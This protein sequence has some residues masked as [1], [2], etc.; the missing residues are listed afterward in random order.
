[1]RE[2]QPT[3]VGL[4]EAATG[5]PTVIL[6]ATTAESVHSASGAIQ[7]PSFFIVGPPRTG[8]SWLHQ[9]LT[10]HALLPTPVKETRFFDKHYSRGLKWYLAQFPAAAANAKYPKGEVAPTYFASDAARERLAEIAPQAKI[11]CVFRNPVER[12]VSLYR[13]KRAYGLIPWSFE[14]AVERDPE[15]RETS[16]YAYNLKLWR[17][18]F[19]GENVMAAI[20]DDLRDDPQAFANAISDFI[21]APRFIL[22]ATDHTS[23]HT[24]E[25][26]THPRSYYR[27][28][29]AT[30]AADWFKAHRLAHVVTKFRRS[31]LLKLVLGGGKPFYPVSASR[32]NSLYIRFRPDIEELELLLG[33][34]LSDWKFAATDAG[35]RRA[36]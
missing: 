23:V 25:K 6:P 19:G 5:N 13:L 34:D 15:I 20:Y 24:S 36:A 28:R 27:T 14:Q 2:L 12:I 16:R 30:L 29:S 11:I 18:S 35:E 17:R 10:G 7:L 31:P 1:M 8:S 32:L 3:T 4:T 21:E 22:G 33:R 26:M 9:V